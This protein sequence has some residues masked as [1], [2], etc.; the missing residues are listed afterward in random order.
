V[1]GREIYTTLENSLIVIEISDTG[2]KKEMQNYP[3][4]RLWRSIG[5]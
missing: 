2:S 5:L 3:C 1:T 4:N